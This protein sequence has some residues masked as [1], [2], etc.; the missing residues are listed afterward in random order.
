M[1]PDYR[2][3]ATVDHR[4]WETG[5]FAVNRPSKGRGRSVRTPQFNEDFCSVLST[6]PPQATA[7][8][9]TQSA[10]IVVLC[11]R[12]YANSSAILAIGSR[13]RLLTPITFVDDNLYSVCVPQHRE[14]RFSRNGVV[15][16]QGLLH[17]ARDFQK[18]QQPCLARRKPS[19]LHLLTA[20]SNVLRS[21]FGR[22]LC[23]TF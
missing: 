11:G 1:F 13:C 3:S 12:S 22:A 6:I 8:L 4:L 20:T 17:P 23:T 14:V 16:E 5:T 18:P 15:H 7:R 21:T 9:V 2:M 10:W 19:L